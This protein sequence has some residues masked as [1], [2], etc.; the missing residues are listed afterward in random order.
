MCLLDIL[1]AFSIS[2]HSIS[3]ADAKEES[4]QWMKLRATQ[5]LMTE[6]RKIFWRVD[7]MHIFEL[8]DERKFQ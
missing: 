4:V 7:N 1:G 8:G 6:N 3:K 2:K 5:A